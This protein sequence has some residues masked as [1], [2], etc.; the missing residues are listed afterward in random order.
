MKRYR[1]TFFFLFILSV[2]FSTVSCGFII[3]KDLEP[4]WAEAVSENGNGV[5][6]FRISDT[7]DYSITLTNTNATRDSVHSGINA[8][9]SESGIKGQFVPEC[10]DCPFQVYMGR[11]IE[12]KGSVEFATIALSAFT[13]LLLP[14]AVHEDEN[15]FLAFQYRD[16]KGNISM[17]PYRTTYYG[18]GNVFYNSNTIEHASGAF[19]D[20]AEESIQ[21]YLQDLNFLK[22]RNGQFFKTI[23]M[24]NN[25]QFWMVWI[26][27][28]PDKPDMLR[29]RFPSGRTEIIPAAGIQDKIPLKNF[30]DFS[31]Q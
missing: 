25:Q 14:V 2:A 8:A 11:S 15:L 26:F 18:M 28:D 17:I 4:E 9:L 30:V 13:F 29:I 20:A 27:D 12:Q 1:F 6:P 3:R 22:S 10:G 21:R 16:E 31:A 19:R 24:D 23:V 5:S 7:L